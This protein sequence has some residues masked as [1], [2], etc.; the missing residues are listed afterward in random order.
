MRP[1]ALALLVPLL[2]AAA[3]CGSSDADEGPT[4]VVTTTILGDVVANL[5]GPGVDVETLIPAN[6]DPHEFQPSAREAQ[7]L[8]EADLVVANGGGL[9]AGLT[10]AL[11]AAEEDGV[12][13]VYALDAIP[14]RED[15]EGHVDPHFFN[16]P[17]AMATVAEDLVDRLPGTPDGGY[18]TELRALDAEVEDTLSV[19]PDDRRV[20]VTNHESLGWFADRYG[21]EVLGVI[22]PGGTTLAEPSAGDLDD[23]AS[24]IEEVGVPAVFADTSSPEQLAESLADEVGGEVEVVELYTE[25]LGGEGSGAETYVDMV[26]T[27]AERIAE[28][29]A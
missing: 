10:D 1:L 24:A 26:R 11:E 3:A 17:S 15:E 20:L 29:L 22:I 7:E 13:V 19:I 6:A 4:V 28:A 5:V 18:L 16:D 9:E 8:R 12:D 21:F 14:A 23:L 25:S 27:N 2:G